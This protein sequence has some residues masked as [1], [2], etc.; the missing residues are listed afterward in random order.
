MFRI[1]VKTPE[2][3]FPFL[4]IWLSNKKCQQTSK[5][6]K[7]NKQKFFH[8]DARFRD[9]PLAFLVGVLTGELRKPCGKF[10]C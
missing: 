2:D 5:F 10:Y 7:P 6:E 9:S 4:N 8:N 1:L 3:Y